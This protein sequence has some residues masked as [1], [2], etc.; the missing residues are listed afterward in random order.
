MS[1]RTKIILILSCVVGLYAVFDNGVLRFMAAESFESW[2]REEAKKSLDQVVGQ[3]EDEIAHLE[4]KCRLWRSW[5]SVERFAATGDAGELE[6][7]LSHRGMEHA[8]VDLLYVLD[9]NGNVMWGRIE[10]PRSDEA[11]PL[12]QFPGGALHTSHPLRSYL[13]RADANGGAASRDAE[14]LLGADESVAG[15]MM[16]SQGAMLVC[17]YP[18]DAP[19][20]P[21]EVPPRLVMGRFVDKGLRSAIGDRATVEL[22]IDNLDEMP[23][24]GA[25]GDLLA[26]VTSTR[27]V[28][29]DVGE[30]NVLR[31]YRTYEDV[32][33]RPSIL[34]TA[35]VERVP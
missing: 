12:R 8:E 35:S 15:L 30:D 4:S 22:E 1:L 16:T 29:Y 19:T 7:E 9:G 33:R 24:G 17:S 18:I 13:K 20:A 32:R 5:P 2:E 3:I 14:T 21:E 27:D 34:L 31:L 10:A 23:I 11:I 6:E 25:E 28:V 26:E